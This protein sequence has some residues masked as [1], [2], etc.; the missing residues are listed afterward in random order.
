[1]GAGSQVQRC[2][3]APCQAAVRPGRSPGRPRPVLLLLVPPASPRV[4]G[5][6]PRST[7]HL[8]PRQGL[9]PDRHSFR[10]FGA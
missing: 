7:P 9:P 4:G 6:L 3:C 8:T 1:M 2:R 10:W 5:L